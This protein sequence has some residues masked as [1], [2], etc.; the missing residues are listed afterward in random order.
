VAVF[1]GTA[2]T[3]RAPVSPTPAEILAACRIRPAAT[4]RFRVHAG[5]LTARP[6][7]GRYSWERSATRPRGAPE[8]SAGRAGV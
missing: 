5:R 1:T 6:G 4:E 7:D 8:D 3:E 2:T